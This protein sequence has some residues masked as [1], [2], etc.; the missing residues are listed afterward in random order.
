M[1]AII[2]LTKEVI[3][4]MIGLKMYRDGTVEKAAPQ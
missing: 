1:T 2:R 3:R 4:K